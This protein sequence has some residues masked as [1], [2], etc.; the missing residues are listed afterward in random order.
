M[1]F[2]QRLYFV[3][4]RWGRLALALGIVTT[5]GLVGMKVPAGPRLSLLMRIALVG[6]AVLVVVVTGLVERTDLRQGWQS[7][8]TL[9]FASRG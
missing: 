6:V 9:R 7:L 8:W 5:L 1:A 3:P 4:H 2:S